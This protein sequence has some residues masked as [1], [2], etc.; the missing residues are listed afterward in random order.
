MLKKQKVYCYNINYNNKESILFVTGPR[1]LDVFASNG[2]L[3]VYDGQS[4]PTE[5][6]IYVMLPEDY[7]LDLDDTYNRIKEKLIDETG[8]TVTDFNFRVIELI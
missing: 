5:L 7:L 1:M 2:I 6:K 4:A 8:L 3:G